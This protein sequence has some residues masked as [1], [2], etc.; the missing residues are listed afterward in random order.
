MEKEEVSIIIPT[1]NRADSLKKSV[2]SVLEQTYPWFELIIVD[3]G[4]TDNTK[5]LVE[6]FGDNRIRYYYAGLNQGAAAARNYGLEKARYDY[7]AFQDSDDIWHPDK[8]EKQMQVM[9]AATG[10]V[11]VVYHKIL[12][13]LG[14]RRYA[15][16]PAEQLALEK[17][18][19]EIY[20]Q[21]LYD[22]LIPCPSILAKKSAVMD[23]GMFDTEL[24][25]LEDYD[26]ALKLTRKYKACFVDEILLDA[27]YSKGGV[28]GNPINY[29]VA[30]C[31]ILTRYKNDYLQTNTFNHRVEIILRDAEA[32]G[33]KEEFV[34]L[35]EKMLQTNG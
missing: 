1:Y 5:E 7:I 25:A 22:N 11:G 31:M 26:F 23:A 24:K 4:S 16:L 2:A 17:K 12:Y 9:Q 21:M 32:I 15:I 27:S 19:G 34:K 18:S 14:E 28:S 20:A 29:L 8:L 30:S 33:M 6:S 35:M 10:E 3:D 13:D